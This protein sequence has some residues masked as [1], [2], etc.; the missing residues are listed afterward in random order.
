MLTAIYILELLILLLIAHMI[1]LIICIK[2]GT[3]EKYGKSINR[4]SF[5]ILIIIF[6][7]VLS[8]GPENILFAFFYQ[9]TPLIS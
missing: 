9:F 3:S 7:L 8:V 6:I 5:V 2:K 4:S 1:F